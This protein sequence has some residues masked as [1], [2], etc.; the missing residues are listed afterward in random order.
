MISA[1]GRAAAALSPGVAGV[2]TDHCDPLQ[3]VGAPR[4]LAL[5]A[6]QYRAFSGGGA[7]ERDAVDLRYVGRLLEAFERADPG[8][9]RQQ[10]QHLPVDRVLLDLA[11]PHSLDERVTPC[12][13]RA[14]HRQ[15]L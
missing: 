4:Q 3:R 13:D 12:A 11:G 6:E 9:Q 10:A 15:V 1:F 5:V 7:G 14:W 2:V 8:G